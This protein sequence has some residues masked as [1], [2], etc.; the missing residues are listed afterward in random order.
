[1]L[2]TVCDGSGGNVRFIQIFVKIYFQNLL[3][4]QKSKVS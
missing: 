4:C 2:T 3:N 1:M